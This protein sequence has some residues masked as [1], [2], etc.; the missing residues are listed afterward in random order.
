MV[1]TPVGQFLED[2]TLEMG[3]GVVPATRATWGGEAVIC[4]LA[5]FN[6]HTGECHTR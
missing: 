4:Q 5:A 3:S 6:I 1:C 2:L